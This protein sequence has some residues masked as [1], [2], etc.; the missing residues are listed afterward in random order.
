M[1]N[2][3]PFTKGSRLLKA[4]TNIRPPFAL[5]PIKYLM[6][7][8]ERGRYRV[9]ARLRLFCWLFPSFSQKL[10]ITYLNA[11]SSPHSPPNAL[12]EFSLRADIP[13][14]SP[15]SFP[16][17]TATESR[18]IIRYSILVR[19]RGT[20]PKDQAHTSICIVP[21]NTNAKKAPIHCPFLQQ[22]HFRTA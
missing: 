10:K 5:L 17:K 16:P 12:S 22:T 3:P 20:S 13:I 21:V 6:R 18:R 8:R 19:K 7:S 1:E 11:K 2:S 15:T 4:Q 9:L 14:H